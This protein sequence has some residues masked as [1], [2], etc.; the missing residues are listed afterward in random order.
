MNQPVSD[1]VRRLPEGFED[2]EH[3]VDR[4][5]TPT[6][7]ERWIN[8]AAMPYRE[9]VSFYEAMLPRAE[10]ATACLERFPLDNMPAS[11]QRLFQLMLALCHAAIAVEVHQAPSI[12]HA[13][14]KHA[15]RI[16]T[17]FQP[18]G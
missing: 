5:S 9:I 4:W 13:P 2:L 7:H 14:P 3:F 8:R 10:E 18:H 16:V 12:R 15:L 6:S 1:D 11:A 17:G